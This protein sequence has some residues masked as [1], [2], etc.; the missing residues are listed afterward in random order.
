MED[1][2][3]IVNVGMRGY[4]WECYKCGEHSD[5]F[6]S[7]GRAE[8]A[9][10]QHLQNH[11]WDEKDNKNKESLTYKN[12]GDGMFEIHEKDSDSQERTAF[13]SELAHLI[14]KYSRENGSGTPDFILA[15]YLENSL[16]IFGQAVKDRE[17]WYGF[18]VMK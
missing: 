1:S 9:Y 17:S 6:A 15:K 13:E 5:Y 7:V 16:K 11:Y 4:R 18:K 10:E 3:S 2:P 12:V 8:D 14:N